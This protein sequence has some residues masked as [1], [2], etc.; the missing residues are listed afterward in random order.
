MNQKLNKIRRNDRAI[1]D[2]NWIK[3]FLRQGA[4]GVLALSVEDQPFTNTNLYAYDETTNAIY[5]H[6]AAQGRTPDTIKL[7]GKVCFTT[8]EI[9]RLLPADEA[10]EFS[11][12]Y[13]SVVVFGRAEI[14][15][16]DDQRIYGLQLLMDKY[17][18]HFKTG[19]DYPDMDN[20]GIKG[21]AV[22]KISIDSW[23]GKQK[24]APPEFPGAFYYT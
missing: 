18:P 19:V 9:G 15:T 2:Q 20:E 1:N 12:E 8:S 13:A 16:D 6:T 4:Y 5:L 22:Y 21:T 3:E 24:E 14:L 7:N 11:V 10:M 23:S 17:F